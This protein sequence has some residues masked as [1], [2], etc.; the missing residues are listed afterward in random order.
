MPKSGGYFKSVPSG[1][2]SPMSLLKCGPTTPKIA[3]TGNFWY[4][5]AQKGL[6][7]IV[8]SYYPFSDFYKI[9]LG[10]GRPRFAP[11]CQIVSLS[12]KKCGSTAS[13]IAKIGMYFFTNLPK[14]CRL[15]PFLQYF[16]WGRE[17]K[18]RTLMPNFTAG[19]LKMWPYGPKKRQKW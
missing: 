17:S 1:Q 9:W 13:K 5:F 6:Y 8:I 4:K 16:A 12:V 3:E 15:K 19:A 14:I 2:I 11:S 7:H 18:H 10:G